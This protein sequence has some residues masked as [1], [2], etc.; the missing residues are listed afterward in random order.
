MAPLLV[1]LIFLGFA[2]ACGA[3]GGAA[4]A[5]AGREAAPSPGGPQDG[6][7]GTTE[8]PRRPNILLLVT[9]DLGAADL[10]YRGGQAR[11]P[12]LDRLA[13]EGLQLDRFY[14][15]PLCTPTRAALLTGRSPARFGLQYRPLRPWDRRGL[16]ADEQVLPELLKRAG[17][18]TAVIG[19]WHLGHGAP[20]QHP[21][22]RGVD[23]FYGMLTG[24][25]DYWSH[26][27]G[28]ALDWQRNGESVEEEGYATALLG[29]E[30]ARWIG[31]IDDDAPFFLLLAFNAPHTPLQAPPEIEAEYRAVEKPRR[32]TYLAMVDALDRAVGEV[33]DAVD[34]AG[35]RDDTLVVFLNDNGGARREGASNG[36][37]RGGKGTCFEGGVR[38]P[39]LVRWPA[40]LPGGDRLAA[41]GSVL[42]LL[43]TLA[44]AA[45]AP[46]PKAELDGRDLLPVWTG[47]EA[48]SGRPLFFGALD[49]R[50]LSRAV[51]AGDWKLLRRQPLAIDALGVARPRGETEEWLL[52]LAADPGERNNLLETDPAGSRARAREL[53]AQLD[54]WQRLDTGPAPEIRSEAPPGWEP[55]A[56]WADAAKP[57]SRRAPQDPPAGPEAARPSFVVFVADDL[58]WADV[59][60]HGGD[61]PTP[62]IDRIAA[63]GVRFQ[64]FQTFALCTPTRAALLTGVD[65]MRLGLAES[66]LRPWDQEG[67]P[68]GVPTL[69]ELLGAAGYDTACVGKWHLGHGDPGMHPNARGFDRFYGCLNGYVDYRSHR[70]RDGAHDWQRDGESLAV[71]GYATRLFAGEAERWIRGRD[72]E[73]PFFLYL[74]FT[75][76]HLP[77]QAPKET[78]EAFAA[79]E[80]RDRRLY[81][82]MVAEL[83]AA[84]ARVL[85][86]LDDTGRA[87]NTMVVFL[88]DNG[89]AKGE[90][91][92]N[93]RFRGGKGSAFE[94]GIRMPA[95]MRW[96]AR[97]EAGGQRGERLSVL[98]L[99]PTVLAVAGVK[100]VE[101]VQL[102]GHD[103]FAG[104]PPPR[105]LFSAAHTGDYHNSTAV[106]MPWK[107]V[108]RLKLDGSVERHLLY[109]LGDDPAEQTDLAAERP[110]VLAE[111][112]AAVDAWRAR[113]PASGAAGARAP[114]PPDGWT[115]PEDWAKRR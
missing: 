70:S 36:A 19:K 110:E 18:H 13:A 12:R 39:A 75:A 67:L 3:E 88:S 96:P 21:N 81:A 80:D 2:G 17:Y 102:D 61:I 23:H 55:P 98:D 1:L 48:A 103:L 30:A 49:E 65:P 84:V 108:R 94:G 33:L 113:A 40:G 52:D 44:A 58:G 83:D 74:P 27:R 26:R 86:A 15:Q 16:P 93:G 66:P 9:D 43:P 22:R 5:S 37:L 109:H 53:G 35:E 101:R 28:E 59:G 114:E 115:P 54:R 20:E 104:P 8:P 56:D 107:Y 73:T 51:V 42:D 60:F 99:A 85:A 14:A 87:E 11:T 7:P 68:A 45:G 79:V 47:A 112:S 76:P 78:V 72:P 46:L 91:G 69:A 95:A 92:D 77:L 71:K 111:L 89:N 100:P 38:V 32:R 62:T 106:R 34:R 64:R 24:A 31:G 57:L 82:A 29:A 41:P 6:V 63:E 105:T 97:V 50:F 90:P 25:A 10:G 4:D